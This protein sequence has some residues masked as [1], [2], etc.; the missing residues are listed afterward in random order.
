MVMAGRQGLGHFF[1]RKERVVAACGGQELPG[2]VT[3][4]LAGCEQR[5]KQ[6]QEELQGL[7]SSGQHGLTAGTGVRERVM[8]SW[9]GWL[10]WNL[11]IVQFQLPC[12]H[13]VGSLGT[14]TFSW[15]L[16]WEHG[17]GQDQ[18]QGQGQ[19]HGQ[20]LLRTKG[21]EDAERQP[22]GFPEGPQ[23]PLQ[24]SQRNKWIRSQKILSL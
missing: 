24:V 8:E 14:G 4:G 12:Q 21:G 20:L 1:S 5:C 9:D 23:D 22:G 13:P 11:K 17:Q 18:G 6:G 16:S 19:G 10:E 2:A 7:A 3:A 15:L